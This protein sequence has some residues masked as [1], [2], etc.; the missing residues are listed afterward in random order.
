MIPLFC[1]LFT[2]LAVCEARIAELHYGNELQ[3]F[4]K[5]EQLTAKALNVT[6]FF[7]AT[8]ECE[9]STV[10]EKGHRSY[11]CRYK[12]REQREKAMTPL[13]QRQSDNDKRYKVDCK[14]KLQFVEQEQ[15][16][17]FAAAVVDGHRLSFEIEQFGCHTN[18]ATPGG[19]TFEIYL[20]STRHLAV[21]NVIDHFNSKYSVYC[22]LPS[23]Y[24]KMAV[25]TQA[26]LS[27]PSPATGMTYVCAD[28]SV[29]LHYEHFDAFDDIGHS[30]FSSLHHSVYR[31][32]V[33]A[34]YKA[35]GG[36]N[37]GAPAAAATAV[38]A[39]SDDP[40]SDP[41]WLVR[42]FSSADKKSYFNEQL[43][44]SLFGESGPIYEWRG[45]VSKYLT[46]SAMKRCLKRQTLWFVG[47]SH[48]RYQFDITM[49]R[50][51]DKLNMGRYH[52][53]VNVSG[54]S[55][56]DNTFST[57]LID[58]LD[59]LPCPRSASE[60]QQLQ[61]L[62]LQTGSWDLQFFPPRAFIRNPRQGKH[63]CCAHFCL[64]GSFQVAFRLTFPS[65]A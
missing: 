3:Q 54:V 57:R 22:P 62:V 55:Y 12:L 63:P 7:A 38:A 18:L 33:C 8:D 9:R 60:T 37:K 35:E 46:V 28:V 64:C 19:A 27:L 49:D 30:K 45:Q 13:W 52:G 56:A 61:T 59:R 4:E 65:L 24:Q 21:C 14:Y 31:G 39:T 10:P 2:L 29:G 1:T 16:S 50:Y 48:M 20:R 15:L 26:A 53:S 44:A 25:A 58:M 36:N 40:H 17:K 42:P 51:V 32:P 47:E 5:Y 23:D 11:M 43:H 6:E 41:L 34:Q